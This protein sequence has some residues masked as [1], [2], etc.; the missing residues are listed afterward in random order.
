MAVHGRGEQVGVVPE[1]ADI[2]LGE[3]PLGQGVHL[4][5]PER[6]AG[7]TDQDIGGY[8]HMGAAHDL[9]NLEPRFR[10]YVG[11][12]GF[13]LDQGITGGGPTASRNLRDACDGDVGRQSDGGPD[14][15]VVAS[16][17]GLHDLGNGGLK[18]ARDQFARPLEDEIQVEA[19]Q[20]ELTELG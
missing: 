13:A 2:G 12:D 14:Q 8:D 20:R 9:G 5:R 10:R 7:S 19:R 11:D 1:E 6:L 3:G 16:R 15:E 18:P 4:Q 17:D